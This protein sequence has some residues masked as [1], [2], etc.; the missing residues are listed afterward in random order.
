[1]KEPTSIREMA[2]RYQRLYTAAIYD[3]LDSMGYP[4]QCL[5]LGI[6][7]LLPHMKIAGVSF[8]VV[9][10]RDPRP[11]EEYEPEKTRGFAIFDHITPGSVVVINAE[12]DDQCGHWGELMS[13]AAQARGAVGVVIDGGIRDWGHLARM[14]NWSVFARYTSP[15]ESGKRWKVHDFGV[16]IVMS[17]TLTRQVR[18]SPGDWIVGDGDG[19]IVIP[20]ELATEVL[21]K[22][23][24]MKEV[25]DKVRA[26]IRAGR[27]V[28]DVFDEYGQL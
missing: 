25:E 6:R 27:R 10:Y 3:V 23:E 8:T 17:G 13:T 26:E 16:P 1:M 4:N 20:K 14:E 24:S 2:Q 7:P 12:K 18:V 11:Q 9:G 5:D 19:V 15:I 21:L 28:K 22:A